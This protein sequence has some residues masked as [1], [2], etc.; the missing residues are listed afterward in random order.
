MFVIHVDSLLYP[1]FRA[2]EHA[3]TAVTQNIRIQAHCIACEMATVVN[4]LDNSHHE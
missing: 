2:K 1:V 3:A 4:H